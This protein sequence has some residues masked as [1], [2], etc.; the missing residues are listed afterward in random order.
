MQGIQEDLQETWHRVGFTIL[1]GLYQRGEKLDV[2]GHSVESL[3]AASSSL[4]ADAERLAH[5]R[6]R[7]RILIGCTCLS[8]ALLAFLW[9]SIAQGTGADSVVEQ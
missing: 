5:D 8:L 7:S 1:P 6:T 3:V 4:R 2:L 9:H